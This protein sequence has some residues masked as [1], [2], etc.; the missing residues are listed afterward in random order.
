MR[1]PL[2][3]L[4]IFT[5]IAREGTLRAAAD[6][7]GLQPSTVSHQLKVLEGQLGVSLFSRTT[8]SIALTEA[9]RALL[10]G[11]GPAFDEIEAAVQAAKDAGGSQRGTLRLTMPGFA[12]DMVIADKLVSFRETYPDVELEISINES[13]VDLFEERFHAGIRL[14]GSVDP[15]MIAVRITPPL[16]LAVLASRDYVRKHGEPASPQELVDHEC[17]RYRFGKSGQF[18]PW[19][20]T[21]PDGRYSVKVSGKLIV[22]TLPLLFSAID[23]GLGLGFSFAEYRPR[24]TGKNTVPLLRSCSEPVAGAYLYYPREY[25]S[26]E[27]LR[28]FVKHVR[29]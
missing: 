7:L 23:S 26:R 9:G 15:D 14:G 21:G 4:E 27:L 22:N 13:F 10:R 25:K 28:L 17:I 19:E 6:S 12:Y 2:P 16:D 1:L 18:A 24:G 3:T 20:F 8:R 11:A 29:G 5:A